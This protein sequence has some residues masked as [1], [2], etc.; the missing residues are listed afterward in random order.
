MGT[1][2]PEAGLEDKGMWFNPDRVF[3]MWEFKGVESSPTVT[4]EQAEKH[5]REFMAGDNEYIS[6]S[7]LRTMGFEKKEQAG[8]ES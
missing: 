8:V 1:E 2:N 3:E 7:D 6:D 5:V 4:A